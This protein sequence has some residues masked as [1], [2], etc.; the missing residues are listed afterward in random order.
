M[1]ISE[2]TKRCCRKANLYDYLMDYHPTC[3]KKVAPET[4]QYLEHDSLHITRGHGYHRFSTDESGNAIDF[5]INY[6]GYDFLGACEAL[7]PYA[8][9]PAELGISEETDDFSEESGCHVPTPYDGKFRRIFAYLTHTKKLPNIVVQKL[10]IDNL[11]YEDTRHNCVFINKHKTFA[12]IK[13]TCPDESGKYYKA[14]AKDS[15]PADYWCYNPSKSKKA[16][17]C[18]SAI[19]ALSLM[20]M[21][22]EDA[23]YVSMGGLQPQKLEKIL[24]D[25]DDVIIAVDSDD[26][27]DEFY[28]THCEGLAREIPYE[29]DWNDD[30]CVL[31]M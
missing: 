31:T 3:F 9:S 24:K 12:E 19:D 27:A 14:N 22:N 18:E 28:N 13:G 15:S 25:F 1:K 2:T 8:P 6:L 16:Y 17:V 4:I 26:K 7:L 20:V 10:I 30:L 21:R 11:L 5:L 23:A 29:K